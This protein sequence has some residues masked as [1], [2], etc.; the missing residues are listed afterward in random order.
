MSQLCLLTLVF[1]FCFV[2]AAS[3]RLECVQRY[4]PGAINSN[5]F[6]CVCNSTYCDTI[7]SVDSNDKETFFQQ[8][9]TSKDKFRLEKFKTKFSSINLDDDQISLQVNRTKHFQKIKG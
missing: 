4:F 2:L 9:I 7:E 3:Q 5:S 1:S 8:F 6:V